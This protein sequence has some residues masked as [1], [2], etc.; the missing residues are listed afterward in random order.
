MA[1]GNM[2]NLL[3]FRLILFILMIVVIAYLGFGFARQ[4]V[5]SQQRREALRKIEQQ[6]AVAQK[7]AEWLEERLRYTQSPEAAEE[8]ARE[9]VWVKDG[10]VSV[11][12][13][14]PTT[15]EV[16]LSGRGADV[17][18]GAGSNHEAWWALFLGEP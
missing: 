8:W 11:V 6:V 16:P 7:E 13:V 5:A 4:A 9:N 3:P 17:E 15:V 14:A 10:E 18:A 2:R 12:V 1:D